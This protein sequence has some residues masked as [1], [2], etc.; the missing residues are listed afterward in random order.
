M[1][2]LVQYND[3]YENSIFIEEINGSILITLCNNGSDISS[4]FYLN[5]ENLDELVNTLKE[6]QSYCK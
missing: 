3:E 5:P 1:K 2:K 4:E 6:A